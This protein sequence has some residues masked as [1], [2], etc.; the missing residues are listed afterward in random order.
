MSADSWYS[1]LVLSVG[2]S[3]KALTVS[4]WGQFKVLQKKNGLKIGVKE[5][6]KKISTPSWTLG[7]R[8]IFGCACLKHKWYGRHWISRPMRIEAKFEETK[9]DAFF[10]SCVIAGH[11]RNT[12]FYQKSPRHPE[13]GFLR[14]GG[15]R[16]VIFLSLQANIRII[17]FNQK[18]QQHPEVCFLGLCAYGGRGK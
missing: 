6:L 12:P 3:W 11:I 17:F 13:L 15:R 4:V 16:G 18:Y 7:E 14:L 1:G 10:K 9:T 8:H 5:V 2:I